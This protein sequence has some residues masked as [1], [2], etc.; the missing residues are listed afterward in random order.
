MPLSR[1]LPTS[2]AMLKKKDKRE[3]EGEGK[4]N[5]QVGRQ[6]GR[7]A[8]GESS[9]QTGRGGRFD[10]DDGDGVFGELRR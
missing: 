1:A 9:A 10:D 5:G 3:K 2:G 6:A 8:D 7:Q 4:G